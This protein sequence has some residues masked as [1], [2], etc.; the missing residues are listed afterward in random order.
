MGAINGMWFGLL[1]IA[2]G[3]LLINDEKVY[4][5]T[6]A[7]LPTLGTTL[8]IAAG[9]DAWFNR[10]ILANSWLVWVGLISYPLYL[11]HW[12]LLA[13]AHI[14]VGGDLTISMRIALV[15]LSIILAWLTYVLIEKPIRYG[16]MSNQIVWCLLLL[17]LLMGILGYDLNSMSWNASRYPQVVLQLSNYN[18][19]HYKGLR[20]ESCL[21]WAMQNFKQFKNCGT[22]KNEPKKTILI[23]GDS[24]AA[25][26]YAGYKLAYGKQFNIAQRTSVS[27]PP[28]IGLDKFDNKYCQATNDHI[29]ADIKRDHPYRVIL[30]ARWGMYPW[31]DIAITI[32][33]LKQVGVSHIDL[34]GPVPEWYFS[35]PHQLS[36]YTIEHKLSSLPTRMSYGLNDQFLTLD[37]NM[38]QRAKELGVNYI[39]ITR[40]MCTSDGCIT[41]IGNAMD[42]LVTWDYGHLTAQGSIYAVSLFPQSNK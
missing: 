10:N 30:A 34:I 21:L 4:P 18:Y 37:L 5:G 24:H 32:K 16:A 22:M 26:L 2:A 40:I 28:I 33:K 35:L 8:V 20:E 15:I 39:S 25:A 9:Y 7:L 1:L 29:Y 11:W 23:W 42:D 14:Q 31:E 36:W 6:W 19:N 27:C 38:K 12:P 3:L 41:R 17:M 13:F